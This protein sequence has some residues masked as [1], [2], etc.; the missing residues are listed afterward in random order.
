MEGFSISVT[1][2][3]ILSPSVRTNWEGAVSEIGWRERGFAWSLIEV[4]SFLCGMASGLACSGGEPRSWDRRDRIARSSGGLVRVMTKGSNRYCS[5]LEGGQ[6]KG[7]SI[8]RSESNLNIPGDH[9]QKLFRP[10][11]HSTDERCFDCPEISV[12][13]GGEVR[14]F[15]PSRKTCA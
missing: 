4:T 9:C 6:V 5:G 3:T 14:T 15:H 11:V 7:G 1:I 8:G 2:W 10:C 13:G 12:P